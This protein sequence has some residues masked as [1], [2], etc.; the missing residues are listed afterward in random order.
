MLQILGAYFGFNGFEKC[1][2]LSYDSCR[3]GS[4]LCRTSQ[5][6]GQWSYV[7][8]IAL[9]AQL[10]PSVLNKSSLTTTKR[11]VLRFLESGGVPLHHVANDQGIMQ[12]LAL[13]GLLSQCS[14]PA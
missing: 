1:I 13:P 10:S 2:G 9:F 5:A 8:F 12:Q 4:I 6:P 11:V 7:Y 14:R 3:P